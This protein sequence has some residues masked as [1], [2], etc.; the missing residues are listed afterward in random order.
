[1]RVVAKAPVAAVMAVTLLAGC[2]SAEGPGTETSAPA[3]TTVT[4]GPAE[5]AS[6]TA[7]PTEAEPEGPGQ[8][9]AADAVVEFWAMLDLLS[10]DPTVEITELG[11]V[12]RG[13]AADQWVSNIQ[14]RRGQDSVQ[15]GD[16][17]VTVTDVKTIEDGR[18]YEVT[19]CLDFSDVKFDGEKPDRGED[20][21]RQQ[22]TY[23]LRPDALSEGELFVT[24]DPLE[25][26]PCAS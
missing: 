25:Y 13:Q 7:K 6:T 12:A 19:A 8:Q 21:D 10:Q 3:D 15:T 20:G 4:T 23:V 2:E 22:I 26:E 9:A 1:M 11:R 16:T 5:T 17:G 14:G 24:D 18:R